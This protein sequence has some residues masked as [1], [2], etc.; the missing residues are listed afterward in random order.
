[1]TPTPVVAPA[2]PAPSS[3]EGQDALPRWRGEFAALQ[4]ALSA[5]GDLNLF[6][7]EAA[8]AP[9][10]GLD[11]ATLAPAFALLPR[12][13]LAPGETLHFD[14]V[15]GPETPF[16]DHQPLRHIAALRTLRVRV[17]LA[18][19]QPAAALAV[20]RQNLAH[21]RAALSAQAGILPLIHATGIWQS[22]LDGAH[23]LAIHGGL[24][25]ADTR[26]LLD[27][28]LA[29]DGL[30][31]LALKRALAG[32]YTGVFRVVVDRLPHTDDPDLLLS[33]ISSLG[34]A[35]ATPLEPGELGLGLT[36]HPLLDRTAT[37]EAYRRDLLHYFAAFDRSAT[38]PRGLY[39]A[40]TAPTLA[41][42][43][44]ELGKFYLYATAEGPVTWDLVLRA[45]ADLEATANPMG[46]LITD[47]LTPAWESLFTSTMRREAQ[48]QALLGLLAWRLHGRPAPW[49]EIVAAGLLTS[50][51]ADP[52]ADGAPLLFSTG[53]DARI[54]SV[55]LNATD[56]GGQPVSGNTGQPDDLVWLK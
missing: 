54:W 2:I 4:A 43:R 10:A 21:A 33:A 49:S 45:R 25:P 8:D 3:P 26:A 24:S 50:P 5:A 39:A 42:Y 30:V 32:E 19:G 13:D 9:L 38:F 40:T 52:F 51:P 11:I 23:A 37:Y 6:E 7:F 15:V 27:D 29:D 12:F 48:R 53:A 47:F 20:A 41:G 16:P 35:E 1:M 36:D 28:L 18:E 14:P 31:T 34:M 44:A 46:K 22:A 55:F 17:L 56:E